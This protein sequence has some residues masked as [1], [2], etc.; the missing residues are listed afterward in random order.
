MVRS[1]MK[2]FILFLCLSVFAASAYAPPPP[3]ADDG[4]SPATF[5]LIS[6]QVGTVGWSFTCTTVAIEYHNERTH[7]LTAAHC[8]FPH[9]EYALVPDR[10]AEWVLGVVVERRASNADLVVISVA[11]ALPLAVLGRNPDGH[12]PILVVGWPRG[13]AKLAYHGYASGVRDGMLHL[14]LPGLVPGMSGS[15]VY[16]QAQKAVCGIVTDV[17]LDAPVFGAAELI[18]RY[19]DAKWLIRPEGD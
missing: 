3:D 15:A 13:I 4:V 12:E 16:C 8:I 19:R 2:R 7:L 9:R 1:H 5:A 14:Y 11:A 6:R 18:S 17:Y 10:S